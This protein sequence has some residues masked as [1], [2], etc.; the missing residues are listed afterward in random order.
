[1]LGL[2]WAIINQIHWKGALRTA[3]QLN[4]FNHSFKQS[5]KG[6][7]PPTNCRPRQ[8]IKNPIRK[9]ETTKRLS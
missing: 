4:I 6:L 1:M 9:V 8:Q 3:K 2:E 7:T 5:W